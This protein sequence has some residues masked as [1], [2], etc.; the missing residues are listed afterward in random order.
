MMDFLASHWH[1]LLP[2]VAI[3]AYMLSAS[4]EK[5]KNERVD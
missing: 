1:C 2:V 4:R 3:A 5:K